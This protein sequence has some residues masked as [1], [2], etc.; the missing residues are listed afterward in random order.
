MWVRNQ[1]KNQLWWHLLAV[2][3]TIQQFPYSFS[4]ESVF[5]TSHPDKCRE[6]KRYFCAMSKILPFFPPQ[7]WVYKHYKRLQNKE[8]TYLNRNLPGHI[9]G[10]QGEPDGKKQHKLFP[11]ISVQTET[12]N[13][14]ERRTLVL[15]DIK[16][17]TLR[18]ETSQNAHRYIFTILPRVPTPLGNT[19]ES[20][21]DQSKMSLQGS[22][23]AP[24]CL[25][26][27]LT[28]SLHRNY[29]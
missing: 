17:K 11:F 27:N 7:W 3:L 26:R 10:N 24:R 20:I 21:R 13:R 22:Q 8:N 14:E 28:Y 16:S 1:E 5:K 9:L 23:T 6:G 15:L 29:F 25:T 18:R 4:S 19:L 12:G 2:E